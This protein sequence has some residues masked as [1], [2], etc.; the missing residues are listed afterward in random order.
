MPLIVITGYPCIGKTKF[1]DAL[2]LY[3]K[4]SYSSVNIVNEESMN[5]IHG[6]ENSAAE[7]KT[8]GT[9]KSAVHHLLN[10]NAVVIVDSTST[11]IKGFRYELFCIAKTIRTSYCLCWVDADTAA[12]IRWNSERN[13]VKHSTATTNIATR[14]EPNL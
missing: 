10:E 9:I 12:S 4:Q 8:R 11:Y 13:Q 6:Y 2:S 14:Y 1:A 5:I 7:K 3:L